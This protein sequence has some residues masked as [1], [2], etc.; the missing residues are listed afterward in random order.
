VGRIPV[1]RRNG[2][3]AQQIDM[4]GSRL[5]VKGFHCFKTGKYHSIPF[6]TLTRTV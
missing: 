4:E 2:D 5:T 1:T 3:P 6:T